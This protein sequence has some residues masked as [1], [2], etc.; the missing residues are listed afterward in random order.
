MPDLD[1]T[2][3]EEA[4]SAMN[5][6]PQESAL[7]ARHLNNL[8]GEGGVD[9]EDGSRST[10]YAYTGKFNDK[11]IADSGLHQDLANKTFVVPSVKNGQILS[12]N[13]SFKNAVSE[14][15]EK[16]PHY[17]SDQQ[18]LSRY[19]QMHDYMERD[20]SDYKAKMLQG[21]TDFQGNTE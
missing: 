17:D 19:M 12:A 8:W 6:S 3:L 5:L 10:L 15:I 7:Y 2:H 9:N 4:H 11:E 20:T 1:N 18:A 16:F 21:D 14:G 13:D